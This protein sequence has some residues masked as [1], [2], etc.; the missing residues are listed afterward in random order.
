MKREKKEKGEIAETG[1]AADLYT[2]MRLCTIYVVYVF[3][4]T[5]SGK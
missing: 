1:L 5:F 3:G 4:F 2:S